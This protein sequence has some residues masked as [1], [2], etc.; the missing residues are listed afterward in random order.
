M[1]DLFF[2]EID[3][4]VYVVR[5]KVFICHFVD[6]AHGVVGGIERF[7]IFFSAHQIR[8]TTQSLLRSLKLNLF[9][10]LAVYSKRSRILEV[11]LLKSFITLLVDVVQT[12]G[13]SLG[14]MISRLA[15]LLVNIAEQKFST[16]LIDLLRFVIGVVKVEIFK[17]LDDSSSCIHNISLI[18]LILSEVALHVNHILLLFLL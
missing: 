14:T 10:V 8:S 9:L 12:L 16:I 3:S 7:H 13:A 2:E 18:L 1:L 6:V 4:V 11:V 17:V 15:R 5:S